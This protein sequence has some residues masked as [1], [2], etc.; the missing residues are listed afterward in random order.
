MRKD[1]A[2]AFAVEGE[3]AREILADLAAR[4][5]DGLDLTIKDAPKDSARDRYRYAREQILP[6]LLHLEDEGK[7]HAALDDVAET[8]KLKVRDLRK[9]L[10]GIEEEE[11]QTRDEAQEDEEECEP[12]PLPSEAEALVASSGVLDRYVEDVA[13]VHGVVKDREPLRL[14]TLVAVG[15]QLAPYPNGKPAGANLIIT[16][17]PGRGKNYVCD[18]VASLLPEGFSLPFE[19]ASAKSL[20]YRAEKDPTILRHT[21]IY[22]NEAEATDTL[23]EMFRP[24]LSGGR[25]SHLTVNK[26]SDGRNAAQELNVE[27]P[28][29]ITIP[30]VRNKLDGQLQTRMLVAELPDYEGQVAAHS[31][32]SS[33]QLLPDYAAK[34]HS[35]K[36]HTWQAALE[37]LAGVRRVVFDL[38]HEG[39]CFDSDQVSHGARL[40]GNLLGLML[41]H[42]WLEQRNREIVELTN[43]EWAVVATP[44]DYG[45]AYSIF[46]PASAL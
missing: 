32:A 19:S 7:R 10:T 42:A 33:K 5:V 25:A 29:S 36:I 37:S 17:E 45:A 34:D 41:A 31:R 3:G 35:P 18:A 43:G 11:R 40:W 27:G 21:W 16:A 20:F 23:V 4:A 44:E 12:G 9:A 6:L 22:P 24:L 38:D 13:R 30:T 14:Q 8:L 39:F 1:F 46:R 2:D 15:A 26:D 28:A